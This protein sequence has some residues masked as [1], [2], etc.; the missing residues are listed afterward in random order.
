M[1][2]KVNDWTY[3]EVGVFLDFIGL[4]EL[5]AQ[6]SILTLTNEIIIYLKVN[7]PVNGEGLLYIDQ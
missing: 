3:S 7:Y 4:P 1:R 2:R 5:E 6:F